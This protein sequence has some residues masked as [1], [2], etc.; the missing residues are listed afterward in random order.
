[1]PSFLI[2]KLDGP[3][4]AWGD[5]TFEDFRPSRDFPTRSALLGL[6]A[7]CLGIEREDAEAQAQLAGSVEFTVRVDL[8]VTRPELP[9]RK[10]K[11]F[12]RQSTRLTDFHTVLAA[13][14]VK[15]EAN[16][17]PK[18]NPNPVVSRREY[19]YDAHFT[20]A[21]GQRE[22]AAYTLE[23][24]ASHLRKPVYTP[25]LGRRSCPLARPLLDA[26]NYLIEAESGIAALAQVLPLGGLIYAET[27]AQERN[28][29]VVRDLP[30]HRKKRMFATR[31]VYVHKQSEVTDVHQPD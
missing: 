30:M 3:M 15:R 8:A 22:P 17:L 24:I 29:I 19:L 13:R 1:M 28:P 23:T 21:V 11:S 5:H 18:A 6:L 9:E 7:A 12:V 25:S 31:K 20:V 14:M 16:G 4:Q 10:G 2:L 27:D 26:E